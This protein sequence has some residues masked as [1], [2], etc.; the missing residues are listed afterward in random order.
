MTNFARIGGPRVAALFQDA[1]R[2]RPTFRQVDVVRLAGASPRAEPKHL[3]W[4]SDLLDGR[5]VPGSHVLRWADVLGCAREEVVL[6]DAEDQAEVQRREQA[7]REAILRQSRRL[8]D[9]VPLL[10]RHQARIRGDSRLASVTH[11]SARLS[12]AWIGEGLLPVGALLELWEQGLWTATCPTCAGRVLITS[13]G[14]SVLSGSHGWTGV[15]EACGDVVS[16]RD[17]PGAHVLPQATLFAPLW[18]AARPLLVREPPP[19]VPTHEQEAIGLVAEAAT[20]GDESEP[21]LNFEE[22]LAVLAREA[23]EDHAT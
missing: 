23:A 9:N 1:L 12:A 7:E 18:Q 8:H 14:G 22:L 20:P 10:V 15:C 6:A 19:A 2:S 5:P 13:V 17:R 4:L 16:F 11:P 3:R 21:A